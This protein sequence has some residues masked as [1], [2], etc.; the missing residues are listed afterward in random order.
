[1]G[2]VQAAQAV[3]RYHHGGMKPTRRHGACIFASALV[4]AACAFASLSALAHAILIASVRAPNGTLAAGHVTLL[5]RYNSRIDAQRSRLTLI[6]P[7]HTE[8]ALEIAR[9]GRGDELDSSVDLTPGL[10][11]VR[12]QA[13]ALDGRLTRGEV[14]FRIVAAP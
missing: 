8:T 12:W 7:D 11:A 2:A 5:F 13:L 6:R 3:A 4:G 14:P 10:Y 9:G 1:M